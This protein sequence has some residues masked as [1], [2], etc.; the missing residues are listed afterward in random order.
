MKGIKPCAEQLSMA[1]SEMLSQSIS[2]WE[3]ARGMAM[4]W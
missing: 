4:T 1:G 3:G 2:V